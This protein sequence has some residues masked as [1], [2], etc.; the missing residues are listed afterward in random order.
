VDRRF[1]RAKPAAGLGHGGV[2]G[3]ER[4]AGFEHGK[5]SITLHIEMSMGISGRN[6]G[7]WAPERNADG[8]TRISVSA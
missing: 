4:G 6:L 5:N 3:V 7:E 2:D 1:E 8:L